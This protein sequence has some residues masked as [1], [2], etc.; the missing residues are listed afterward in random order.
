MP[1]ITVLIADPDKASRDMCL[2]L[3][4]HERG[5]RVVGEARS[6]LEV[7]AS[8]VKFRPAILL[9]EL[10][11]SHGNGVSLIPVIREKSPQTKV[12]LLV[13]GSSDARILEALSYGA[14]GSLEKR[15]LKTFL[16]KAVRVVDAGEAWVSRKIVAKILDRLAHL[17]S[18][19]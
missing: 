13:S 15:T 1:V 3:L 9:L 6:G 19:A 4:K 14:V 8:S 11:L 18:R 10:G 17:T 12:I 16:A 2:S 7:I 5:I